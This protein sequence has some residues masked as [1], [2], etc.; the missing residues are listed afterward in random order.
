MFLS[1]IIGQNYPTQLEKV[2]SRPSKYQ[3]INLNKIMCFVEGMQTCK[4]TVSRLTFWNDLQ[5]I[6]HASKDERHQ[7]TN[8]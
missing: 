5:I 2:E 6:S 3:P 7:T 8:H 1:F 4:C